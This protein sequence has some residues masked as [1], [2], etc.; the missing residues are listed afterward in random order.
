MVDTYLLIG[1]ITAVITVAGIMATVYWNARLR[2]DKIVESRQSLLA[3]VESTAREKQK[4]EQGLAREVARENK[5]LA[6]EVKQ[7]MKDHIDRLIFTLK[8]DIELART[9]TYSK[10]D[11]TELKV[12][13]LKIDLM[14]HIEYEK[15]EMIRMQRSIDFFQTMQYGPEAKSIPPYI[16]G[17][18]QTQEHKDEPEKGVFASREDTTDKDSK[19]PGVQEI[20]GEF[21]EGGSVDNPKPKEEEKET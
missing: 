10:I 16:T 11:G 14:N 15:D 20:K 17:E 1:I 18:E 2:K 19:D 21:I 7:D 4:E 5:A 3:N 9:N 6:L 12:A 13:Q 8:G